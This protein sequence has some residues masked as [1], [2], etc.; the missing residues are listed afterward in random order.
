MVL[1]FN[2]QISNLMSCFHIE[3]QSLQNIVYFKRQKEAAAI[4]CSLMHRL[5]ECVCGTLGF[6]RLGY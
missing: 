5:V 1:K 3:G 4:S 2:C 6:L